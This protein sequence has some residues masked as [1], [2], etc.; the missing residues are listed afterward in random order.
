MRKTDF[1]LQGTVLH[2]GESHYHTKS[3]HGEG[4]EF[5]KKIRAILDSE[6][7]RLFKMVNE[8]DP[9]ARAV[10]NEC[11]RARDELEEAL[12]AT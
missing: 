5:A 7:R 4:N 8:D 11:I 6:E 2:V 3:K 12:N 9:D 10:D 1:I